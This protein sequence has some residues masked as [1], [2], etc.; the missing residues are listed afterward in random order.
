LGFIPAYDETQRY[1]FFDPAGVYEGAQTVVTENLTRYGGYLNL[2]GSVQYLI[3]KHLAVGIELGYGLRGSYLA[4][5]QRT[6]YQTYNT[7]GT[8]VLRDEEIGNVRD[9]SDS[10]PARIDLPYLS[11]GWRF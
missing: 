1:E 6:I 3:G 2:F 8:P 5:E 10:L 9:L 11:F 4:G 7:A